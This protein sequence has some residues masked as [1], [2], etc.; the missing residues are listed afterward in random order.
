MKRLALPALAVTLVVAGCDRRDEPS[1]APGRLTPKYPVRAVAPRNVRPDEAEF[2]D[3][4]QGVPSYGGH[5]ID[6]QGNLAAYVADSAGV[7]AARNALQLRLNT[8]VLRLA[9]RQRGAGNH[10]T[11]L[12]GKYTYQQLSDWRDLV[13]E[14]VLGRVSGVSMDDMDEGNNR[15]TVGI[16][17]G[18]EAA[19]ES[20]VLQ[21]VATFGI[22]AGAIH[23]ISRDL[24]AL[25]TTV[26]RKTT[27]F[28]TPQDLDSFADPLAGGMRVDWLKGATEE[29]CTI[30]FTAQLASNIHG[31]ITASHCS[32]QKFGL[33]ATAYYQPSTNAT[34][35]VGTEYYDL[36]GGT[37]PALWPC[38]KYRYSDANFVQMS[39]ARQWR[40]G[41]IARPSQRVTSHNAGTP[42]IDANHPY[43][44]VAGQGDAVYQGEDV[45]KIG[46]VSGWTSGLVNGTCVDYLP[47]VDW[48]VDGYMTRCAYT[49]GMYINGGDSG[50]PVF[51]WDGLDGAYALGVFFGAYGDGT[52]YFS[53]WDY[54][55]GE[56]SNNGVY[57]PD[58]TTGVT[59]NLGPVS[60]SLQNG[61]FPSFSWSP[62]ST[63]N[64]TATTTYNVYRSV[65]DA[66]T[67]TWIE[68]G[69]IIATIT[70][71][72][73]TDTS[74]PVSVSSYAGN[75]QPNQCVYTY[76]SY[77]IQ[78][79][80]MGSQSSS[81][82]MF[83][84]LAT[85]VPAGE[86]V[87]PRQ[88]AA[89]RGARALALPHAEAARA[90]SL[91]T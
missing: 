84:A 59:V 82:G 47:G 15:V 55:S 34:P 19:A 62:A 35:S 17:P 22:P 91:A 40:R 81:S 37:C 45:D 39:N 57:S 29:Q 30:G 89:P 42:N 5:F 36:A 8:N 53:K 32:T 73:F 68:D 51:F 3:I 79:Y 27:H 21:A 24:P 31:F 74:P 76:I 9:P 54:V 2:N 6:A 1:T 85:P 49:A 67:Y 70:G 61:V 83:F 63:T 7:A 25:R 46:S 78:A 86:I 48:D 14:H 87:A 88:R 38:S 52:A 90:R 26:A 72:S 58:V 65:W 75:T 77:G 50:S 66:S 11:I 43:L 64:T 69:R 60:A 80:N 41:I 10:I 71:T 16:V 4:A 44:Y 13:F 56:L 12:I 33:D 18:Q 28:T 20:A 23:F